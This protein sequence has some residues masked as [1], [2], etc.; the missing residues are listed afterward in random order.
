MTGYEINYFGKNGFV[1]GRLIKNNHMY[2]I[3]RLL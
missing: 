1:H 2:L 3:L